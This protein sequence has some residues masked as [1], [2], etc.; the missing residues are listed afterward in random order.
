MT[1]IHGARFQPLKMHS[2]ERG[3]LMEVLRRDDPFFQQFGQ[4][5]ITTAYPGVTKAWHYHKKQTDHFC[6]VAGMMKVV[7]Y[8]PREDS[9]TRGEIN[10]FFTGVHNRGLVIIPPLVY[11]GFKCISP[12]EAIVVNIPTEAY[13]ASEPDEFRLDPHGD[14]IPY[15]WARHDG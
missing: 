5:Y 9:P 1:L 6:V 12:E 13:D 4:A 15:D 14:D 2:D 11:H 3:N 7:L 8:D 10:E